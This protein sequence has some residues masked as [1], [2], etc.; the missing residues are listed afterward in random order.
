M[1]NDFMEGYIIS[2]ENKLS[3]KQITDINY[4]LFGKVL[5]KNTK[6]YYY[7]GLLD[8]VLYARLGNGCYMIITED[9]SIIQRLITSAEFKTIK[10]ELYTT[11]LNLNTARAVKKQKYEGSFVKNL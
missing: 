2:Y 1:F 3:S 7:P 4:R 8:N 10:A 6:K 5:T 11:N 9:Q